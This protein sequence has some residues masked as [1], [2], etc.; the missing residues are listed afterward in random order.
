MKKVAYYIVLALLII[1]C[2]SVAY[3][4]YYYFDKYK[5]IDKEFT[6]LT[7]KKTMLK[8]DLKALLDTAEE[9]KTAD[10][11]EDADDTEGSS[12]IE[13]SDWVTYT[14]TK[15]NFSFKHP[16]SYTT[17]GCP[18]KPCGEFI[19]EESGGDQT[20]MQGDISDVGWPNIAIMHLSSEYYNPPEGTDLRAWI[21]ETFSY[22]ADYISLSPNYTITTSEGESFQG[23]DYTVPS[24]PQS[25]SQRY[26][27][28]VNN[29]NEMFV[30]QLYDYESYSSEFYDAWLG[31]FVY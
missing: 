29:D 27:N 15:Y 25:Y 4:A 18:T 1:I 6:E 7:D 17:A 2:G 13:I 5:K 10:E 22:Y 14:N 12:D 23:Y 28:F 24:S 31:T 3:G 9:E 21:L 16:A 26:I 30:I 8:N 20:I 11:T 19:G